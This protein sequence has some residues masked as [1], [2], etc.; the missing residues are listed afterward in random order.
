MYGKTTLMLWRRV[1]LEG[2]GQ[3]RPSPGSLGKGL[4]RKRIGLFWID[5]TGTVAGL[6]FGRRRVRDVA[7]T[8]YQR[9]RRGDKHAPSAT[10]I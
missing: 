4:M 8:P 6:G 10:S 9:L 1:Q 7:P 3:V 5:G 2:I